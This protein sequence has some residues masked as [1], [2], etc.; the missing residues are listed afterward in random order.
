[1]PTRENM[2]EL[3]THHTFE[4]IPAEEWDALLQKNCCNVPFLRH[5]YLA[6]W[7]QYKGGG[8]WDDAQ[9]QIISAR[10]DGQLIGIAPLFSATHEGRAK[11]LFLGSIEISD[12]LD[13]IH[14]PKYSAEFFEALFDYLSSD[15]FDGPHEALLYNIPE[16]SLTR[17]YVEKECK[18]H[19]CQMQAEQAYH[20][21]IIHLA[22]D[23]DNYLA[24]IDKKQRHEIRRKMRRAA[25]DPQEIRWYIV[26]DPQTLDAEIDAFFDLMVTDDEKKAFLTDPM[27]DQLR[28][29]MQWAFKENFLQLSFMT[30][31]GKKAAAY[32]CFDYGDRIWVYNSGFDP[33]FRE[34]SPGWVMLS[35][36]IQHAIELGKKHFD[37]MRGDEEYKYRFGADDSHVFK[38][39]ITR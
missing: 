30:I 7:W 29:I 21:P 16:Q 8:E 39:A 28:S 20:T 24:G 11:L 4:D 1:M 14:D 36:L 15:D 13:F 33:Q 32:L 17:T 18:K 38:V 2:L 5:G 27:R 6:S 31:A 23:W 10:K 19:G 12:Y 34:F 37:F 35:Y 9:L 25:E 22:D 26:D 3:N